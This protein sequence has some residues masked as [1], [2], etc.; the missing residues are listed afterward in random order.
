[1]RS[2]LQQAT[3][4]ELITFD[5][6]LNGA[7]IE[8]SIV[9]EPHSILLGETYTGMQFQGYAERD[10][11][12]SALYA[13][14]NVVLDASNLPAGVTIQWTGGDNNPARVLGVYGN[15]TLKNVSITGG[16]SQA[17]AIAGSTAQPYTLARGGGLAVWG[18]A[19]LSDCAIY[20]NKI[21]GDNE[22]TR[23]RGALGGGIYANGLRLTHCM[24]SGNTA[25]GY[26]AAGGG[27]Y[28]LGG[29]DNTEGIGNDTN[30]TQCTVT[31][32]RVTGQSAYGGGIFT[33]SGGP[34]NLATMTVSNCTVARNLV[35]DDPDLPEVGQYY[36][37]GGGLY[38]GG[39]SLK[40]ISS[41][42][43]ENQ[44]NGPLATF[45]GKP[46]IGGG[47]VAATI[48]NAHV[49]ENVQ[50]Q[51]SIV[52]GN[53]I[54]GA[55]QDWYAGSLI[56]F[57]S[58]GYNRIG[59]IDFSQILVPCP[60]W[61]DLSR[62]HYPGVG[63]LDGLDPANVLDLTSIHHHASIVSAGTDA[64][65]PAVLWYAPGAAAI[66]QVPNQPYT[67]NAVSV[68]YRGFGVATDDFLNRV[69]ERIRAQY[70]DILG[71]DF[72]SDFGDLSGVTWY[73]PAKTWPTNP[74]NAAWITFWH[75][76]DT[77]INGRLGPAGLNDSFWG[78]FPSGALDDNVS[79]TVTTIPLSA[80]PSSTDQQ[81]ASRPRNGLGDI[82]AIEK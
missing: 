77:E 18:I 73:G 8:L 3:S 35:E 55:S 48:G 41:T 43:A 27:I 2:A 69:L 19:D 53:R 50:L 71:S 25:K 57:Y 13:R 17:L 58:Y 51:S 47:G 40:L 46:N 38:L 5:S 21:L 60:E 7:T 31:G 34:N 1:M 32:N 39:G 59:S 42:V 16:N 78:S 61:M 20:G 45:S 4:G 65:R 49:V 63:D 72:G 52:A 70:G 67:F 14:K 15:L 66:D 30:L 29:A 11:G 62:R 76:L 36:Y 74:Q 64:G 12:P 22:A 6:S 75:N 80:T 68:G 24:V 82:G 44:V 37:R 26:G 10:Y 33:L 56:N 23:D 28:S 81:G 9:G 79:V 54:N